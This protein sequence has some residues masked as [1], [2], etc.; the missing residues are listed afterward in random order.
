MFKTSPRSIWANLK[1]AGMWQKRF[2][3]NRDTVKIVKV[4]MESIF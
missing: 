4:E 2:M 1:G 3:E